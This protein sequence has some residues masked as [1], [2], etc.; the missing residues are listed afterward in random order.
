[1]Q[2]PLTSVLCPTDGSE[3]GSLPLPVAYSLVGQGGTVHL[4]HVCEPPFL[5]NPL[6]TNYVQGYIPT[7]EEQRQ[8]EERVLRKMQALPPPDAQKRGVRTEY[9]LVHGINVADVI[10]ETSQRVGAGAVVMGT[11]GR[12]GLSRLLLGSVASDVMKKRIPVILVHVPP[13]EGA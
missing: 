12:T 2:V 3:S 7:P 6:Y 13:P 10:E 1:M 8:G 9:H 5:G 4:L 11:R